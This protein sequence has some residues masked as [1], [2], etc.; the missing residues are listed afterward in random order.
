[1]LNLPSAWAKRQT[2]VESLDKASAQG[3]NKLIIVMSPG[4]DDSNDGLSIESPILTLERAQQII[5]ERCQQVHQHVELRIAPGEYVGQSVNWV[6][7]MP[8][9]TIRLMPL[10][11]DADANRPRFIGRGGTWFT[12]SHSEGQRTNL[13][14]EYMWVQN[15][16]T[17]ISFNGMRDSPQHFNAHNKIYGCY[18]KDIGEVGYPGEQSTACVR[19]LN[20][21][22]NLIRAN[23]FVNIVNYRDPALIH[24]IYLAHYAHHNSIEANLF[25]DNSGDPIRVRDFSNFNRVV[26]N[27]R[28]DRAGFEAAYSEWY[29]HKDRAYTCTK[30]DQTGVPECPSWGNE[31]RDNKI[32][33]SFSGIPMQPGWI[34]FE[35]DDHADCKVPKANI[36]RLETSGNVPL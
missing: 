27:N 18:F 33:N 24:A 32:G 30:V 2:A 12:L 22:Y 25:I 5:T 17:A 34:V 13:H 31:F 21:C 11:G 19:L 8:N 3:G 15:Y 23:H 35:P 20:S 9:H 14:L 7:T 1:M 16:G 4:G 29:C 26:D 10:F 36:R 6:F 28:F